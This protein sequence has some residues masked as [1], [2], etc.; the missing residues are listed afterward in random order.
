MA[1]YLEN[2]Y[3][4][5]IMREPLPIPLRHDDHV[6][7]RLELVEDEEEIHALYLDL[8]LPRAPSVIRDRTNPMEQYNE[9][10]FRARFR[11][12]KSATIA[13]HLL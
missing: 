3:I 4:P 1:E 5:G 9:E 10:G 7:E 13:M 2:Q 6:L 11:V 8:H 12:T